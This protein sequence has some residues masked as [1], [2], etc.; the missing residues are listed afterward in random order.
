MAKKSQSKPMKE[1]LQRLD[2]FEHIETLVFDEKVILNEPVEN[3]PV[4]D[5]LISFFSTGF[6]LDKAIEYKNL[7]QTFL[8][9]DLFSQYALQD[10]YEIDNKCLFLVFAIMY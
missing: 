10:R 4:V 8:L 2:R 7:R 3:W 5:A 1:I 9:N 6:P